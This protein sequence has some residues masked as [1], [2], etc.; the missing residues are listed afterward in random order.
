[1]QGTIVIN[2]EAMGALCG[3]VRMDGGGGHSGQEGRGGRAWKLGGQEENRRGDE[4]IEGAGGR[5]DGAT[6]SGCKRV[7]FGA[8]NYV[9]WDRG[10]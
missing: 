4:T 9:T 1:M 6:W 2:E 8:F 5:H 3:L 10:H 7:K